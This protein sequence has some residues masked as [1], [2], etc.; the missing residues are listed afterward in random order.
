MNQTIPSQSGTYQFKII[1]AGRGTYNHQLI[2]D[3]HPEEK[4]SDSQY[5]DGDIATSER[6]VKLVAS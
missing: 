2:I 6:S 3:M 5:I 1:S 4:G